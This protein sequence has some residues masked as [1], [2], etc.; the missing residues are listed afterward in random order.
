[1]GSLSGRPDRP[2]YFHHAGRKHERHRDRPFEWVMQYDR[3][4]F[5]D[6]G[7]SATIYPTPFRILFPERRWKNSHGNRPRKEILVPRV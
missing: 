7:L 4:L 1:M 6:I 3:E 2:G 5:A